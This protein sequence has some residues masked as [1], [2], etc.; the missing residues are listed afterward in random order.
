MCNY[1]TAT[2][3]IKDIFAKH[4]NNYKYKKGVTSD[5]KE[6]IKNAVLSWKHG[7]TN[8]EDILS[9]VLKKYTMTDD[10]LISKGI[11]ISIEEKENS[12]NV[13]DMNNS[14]GVSEKEQAS[15]VILKRD[16]HIV[17]LNNFIKEHIKYTEDERDVLLTKTFHNYYTDWCTLN[18]LP[19][20]DV[21][22]FGKLLRFKNFK[23][24]K[25]PLGTQNLCMKYF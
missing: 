16:Q 17:H 13:E 8:E 9:N 14:Q 15:N 2:R 18:N 11:F 5:E 22:F 3:F 7:N 23:Q 21:R 12:D 4:L 10:V 20:C 1:K 19:I 24:I 6:D 25:S